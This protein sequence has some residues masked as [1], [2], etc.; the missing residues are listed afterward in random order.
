MA[1]DLEG[2]LWLIAGSGL[3][4][5][6]GEQVEQIG[7]AAGLPPGGGM[8][9][10]ED[11]RG[12]LWLT[13]GAQLGRMQNGRW[14]DMHTFETG[15]LRMSA[16]RGGGLWLCS[17]AQ[18]LKFKEGTK[19]QPI[20]QLPEKV[21]VRVMLEDQAGALWVGTAADGLWRLHG[22]EFKPVPVS[23]REISALTEDREGNLWVGT[24]GGGLNLLR[25][26]AVELVGTESGLPLESVRSVCEDVDGWLWAALQNGALARGRGRKW[27]PVGG[28]DGWPGG[29]VAC[30][31]PAIGG[32]VWI[33]TRDRGLQRLKAGQ[34]EEWAVPE[35]AGSRAIRS[36]LGASNGDLLLALDAPSR[37]KRFRAGTFHSLELPL[38][39]RSIRA[40]AEGADG[41]IWAGTSDGKILQVTG[42]TVTNQAEAWDE[43][44]QSVRC[45]HRAADGSL[46][47]GF[48]GWGVGRWRG[49]SFARVAMAEGL[50]DDYVSQMLSDG[51][52]ALW[53]TGN[54]GLFQ[55]RLEEMSAVAEGR[56]PRLRSIA[57]G[58]NE[59][60]P[61][62][63]P[64]CDNNP[65]AWR[66][67]DGEL[68]FA[69]RK[70]LLVVSPTQIRD[71]PA[72]PPVLLTSV[73]VDDQLVALS[74]SQSPLRVG[75]E[76]RLPDLRAPDL[77]LELAPG[78]GK[79]EFGFTA[80]S[81]SSPENVHFRHRLHGFDTEWVEAGSQRSARY[82]R[83]PA[84]D[85]R[86]EVMAC[87]EAGL[88]NETSGALAFAVRPFLWQ[89]WWF[90]A[91]VLALFTGG[92]IGGARYFSFRRLRREL[93]RL[94]HQ[95]ALQRERTRIARDMHDEV[96]AKLSRLSLLSEMASQQPE[97]PPSARGEVAEI[98]ETARETIRSFEEIVWA[99]NPKNDSLADLVNYLC[100]FAEELFDGSPVQCA[101]EV[102][103]TIPEIELPTDTRHHVFLA[104]K[105]A[106][107]NVLRHA[108]ARLV[109]LKL[110]L[111]ATELEIVIADDG[112]GFAAERTKGRL[113]GGNGLENMRE[114]MRAIGGELELH[115]RP[116]EG[117]SVVLRVPTSAGKGS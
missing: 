29:N 58:R 67:A 104:A 30:V 36:L 79:L 98:S 4:R 95:A 112:R 113:G 35:G 48:A 51:Q 101:F 78:H 72:P 68:W 3:Y 32:G 50:Y 62:L 106:L 43:G 108:G 109:T 107:N 55:V 89:T 47:A 80:L 38:E 41:T 5:I 27:G 26:R 2:T 28:A 22:N 9:L 64:V 57:F 45:L 46:L 7:S 70:G 92:V 52:G 8:W 102:P 40:L 13:R 65:S 59:G 15:P 25:P 42:N 12:Q 54:H 111:T 114:R 11:E 17:G 115:T 100:R 96:G 44:R 105:E 76:A 20:A 84:G 69:T 103:A 75:P 116:G 53:M 18:V 77:R 97:M 56:A 24:T 90:R 66:S 91:C 73:H 94:E 10:T 19:P 93:D 37:L 49:G 31:A 110:R 87:N 6:V 61:S 1:E 34:V 63:Q 85:Y 117:T 88:W 74:D 86:F 16:A 82:P 60:L 71:N 83:L 14:L 33:G 21:T 81:Y 23:H 39:V 99:V